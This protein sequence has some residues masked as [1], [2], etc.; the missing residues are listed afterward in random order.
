MRERRLLFFALLLL[1]LSLGRL[2]FPAETAS[3]R[4]LAEL[5]LCPGAAERV[6][7]WGRALGGEEERVFALRPGEE[8]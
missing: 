8:P 4:A 2:L 1:L 5:A 6:E 3:L 7:A